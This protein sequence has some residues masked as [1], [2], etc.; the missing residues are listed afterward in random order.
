MKF[1]IVSG[2]EER[3]L[4][5][6]LV[7]VFFIGAGIGVDVM[8]CRPRKQL[9]PILKRNRLP[10]SKNNLLRPCLVVVVAR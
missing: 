2:S 10:Q 5:V 1:S 4:L 8:C 3:P 6:M 9:E 7:L